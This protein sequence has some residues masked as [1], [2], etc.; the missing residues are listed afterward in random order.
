MVGPGRAVAG[1]L[2]P[3]AHPERGGRRESP[4]FT[5]VSHRFHHFSSQQPCK[6]GTIHPPLTNEKSGFREVVT[7]PEPHAA[8]TGSGLGAGLP[9]PEFP[10]SWKNPA[11]PHSRQGLKVA[12]GFRFPDVLETAGLGG[13]RAPRH[14]PW[15]RGQC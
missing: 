13:S 10:H 6:A 11:W 12:E 9:A 4:V 14:L 2:S 8:D 5:A 1:S 3:H 15:H 7:H